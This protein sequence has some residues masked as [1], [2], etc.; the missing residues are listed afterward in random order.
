M[1]KIR[2]LLCVTLI[3]FGCDP[4]K[5]IKCDHG[6]CINKSCECNAGWTGENC[7]VDMC[8]EVNC[9]HGT[10]ED[11]ICQCD[12]N[13]QGVNCDLIINPCFEIDC[14]GH[15]SC[16]GGICTCQ[17]GWSGSDCSISGTCDNVDCGSHG[18]CVKGTCEC[19]SG[20]TGA[21]CNTEGTGVYCSNTCNWAG[22]GE[23][24][25]GGPGSDYNVCKCGTDCS[26]CGTRSES[27]CLETIG[28]GYLGVW[29][30]MT[31][32]PCNTAII[33]VWV[34]AD[35]LVDA[36]DGYITGYF[37]TTP[38]CGDEGVVTLELSE[39]DHIMYAQCD[40]GN[41]AWGPGTITINNG[42]CLLIELTDDKNLR[43]LLKTKSKN[44]THK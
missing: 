4:C 10:C 29:T 8:V 28:T 31:T 43:K 32:F 2:L 7:D 25:D 42:K 30:S 13:Y 21:D 37:N 40:N 26:D 33:D 6:V 18:H 11:G 17:P 1:K 3:L 16:A 14:G 41:T 23:C 20:W 9:I 38:S 35:Y 39:G 12:D 15:G 24:D 27:D 5:D 19:D 44:N 34:D 36:P 22:D